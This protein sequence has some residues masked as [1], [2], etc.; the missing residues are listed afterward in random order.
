[1]KVWLATQCFHTSK[2]LMDGVN[3][4]LHILATPFSDEGLQ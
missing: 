4:W 1:M 3:N 2:E